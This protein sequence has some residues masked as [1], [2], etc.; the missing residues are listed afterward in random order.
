MPRHRLKTFLAVGALAVAV[1]AIAW[2][3]DEDPTYYPGSELERRPHPMRRIDIDP[4]PAPGGL[5]YYGKLR[6]NVF[7][8][9]RGGVDRVEVVEARVP[10]SFRDTAVKAFSQARWEPGLRQ[11]KH[12]RSL[13]VVEI[14]FEPPVRGLNRTITQP[15][16]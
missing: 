10:A 9:S 6:M 8:N 11:G 1:A 7:I 13:K 14:D 16:P 12:V 5:E 3:F 4:P 2:W 15:D